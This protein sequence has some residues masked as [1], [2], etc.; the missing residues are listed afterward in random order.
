MPKKPPQV[1]WGD[2]IAEKVPRAPVATNVAAL[3][4]AAGGIVP[5]GSRSPSF[6]SFEDWSP[7]SRV[8][9]SHAGPWIATR[10]SLFEV[11][12]PLPV[13]SASVATPV[14]TVHTPVGEFVPV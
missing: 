7:V 1:V 10:G 12:V 6:G 8:K 13:A 11:Q 14:A 5:M 4:A 3:H 2:P 9:R